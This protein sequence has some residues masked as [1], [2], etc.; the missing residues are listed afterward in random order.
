MYMNTGKLGDLIH[1]HVHVN[2]HIEDTHCCIVCVHIHKLVIPA[3]IHTNTTHHSAD[4]SKDDPDNSRDTEHE[5]K[6]S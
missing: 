6:V 1:I 2:K 5:K 3:H 4:Q